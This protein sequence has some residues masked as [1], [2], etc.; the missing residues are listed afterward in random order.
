MLS[1]IIISKFLSDD[2]I[3]F[4][5][6]NSI[7]FPSSHDIDESTKTVL[8]A[9]KGWEYQWKA[10]RTE[11]GDKNN[12]YFS[13]ESF[14][15][16]IPINREEYYNKDVLVVG[17]GFG[18]EMTH[19]IHYSC[20]NIFA[21]DISPSMYIAN[22]PYRASPQ[23]HCIIADIMNLPFSMQF[24]III[25]DHVLHHLPVV[26]KGT[27]NLIQSVKDDGI[28]ATN[29]YSLENNFIMH[30]IIEPLK[31]IS[32]DFLPLPF[33]YYIAIV[34]AII[35]FLV[36][37]MYC[38]LNKTIG[39]HAHKLPLYDLFIYWSR[40]SLTW[41]WKAR[42]FDLLQSPLAQYLSKKEIDALFSSYP[43]RLVTHHAG[44][45]WCIKI[46]KS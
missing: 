43:L 33:K 11:Y 36:A 7:R 39:H 44:T 9:S 3:Q 1:N 4:Y 37:K 24:D 28:F 46:I 10:S 5:Q 16:F 32:F 8:R 25:A 21:I 41:L 15:N 34:P 12:Y 17:T 18:K 13:E 31:K 27:Y 22:E 14:Y 45:M 42:I 29:Y 35:C 30:S 6:K 2:M 40:S 19:L 20:K 23:V 26:T 38:L